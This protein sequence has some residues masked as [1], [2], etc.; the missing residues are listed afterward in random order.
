MSEDRAG[1][2]VSPAPE[3]EDPRDQA[4]AE[5]GRRRRRAL[6]F[7]DLLPDGTR[8]ERGEVWSEPDATGDPA[9]DWLRREVPPHHG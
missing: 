6:V 7:G 3:T 2:P 4:L 8:D 5:A 1:E 9:E